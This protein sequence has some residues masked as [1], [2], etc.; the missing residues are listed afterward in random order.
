MS[1]GHVG[2]S[3]L[4]IDSGQQRAVFGLETEG[5]DL[6]AL[7]GRKYNGDDSLNGDAVLLLN[8]GMM[9]GL[10]TPTRSSFMNTKIFSFL[11]FRISSF[12][13]LLICAMRVM[14]VSALGLEKNGTEPVVS[15]WSLVL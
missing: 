5:T 15:R 4:I 13:D 12:S 8:D 6:I 2:D 1:V 10:A 9:Q 11:D 3:A 14:L 7:N